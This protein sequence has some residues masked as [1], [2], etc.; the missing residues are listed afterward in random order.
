MIETNSML[1]QKEGHFQSY[2]EIINY[3]DDDDFYFQRNFNVSFFSDIMDLSS[4]NI[5]AI[6]ERHE[7]DMLSILKG[8]VKGGMETIHHLQ[9]VINF[10][11]KEDE[12]YDYKIKMFHILKDAKK[13]MKKKN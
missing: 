3:E 8:S 4:T 13:F 1:H 5:S 7:D 11:K 12:F 6:M 2:P 9:K 10:K